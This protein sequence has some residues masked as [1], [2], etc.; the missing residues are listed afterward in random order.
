[1]LVKRRD[2]R[3]R[4]HTRPLIVTSIPT[5]N[6]YHCLELSPNTPT[7][8]QFASNWGQKDIIMQMSIHFYDDGEFI[9]SPLYSNRTVVSDLFSACEDVKFTVSGARHSSGD[10]RLQW[11]WVAD[12][13]WCGASSSSDSGQLHSPFCTLRRVWRQIYRWYSTLFISETKLEVS[14]DLSVTPVVCPT[15]EWH[16]RCMRLKRWRSWRYLNQLHLK[17]LDTWREEPTFCC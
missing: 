6:P 10:R 17:S 16:C 8:T 2:I 7:S 4:S 3:R 15:G 1:M 12:L 5:P 9:T 14:S 13:E 11:P